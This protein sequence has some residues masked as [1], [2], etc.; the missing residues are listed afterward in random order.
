MIFTFVSYTMKRKLFLLWLLLGAV[1][2]STLPGYR[3]KSSSTAPADWVRQRRAHP[4]KV[5]D[6][7]IGL[8]QHGFEALEEKLL[9]GSQSS[10]SLQPI[11]TRELT[12][13]VV[14]DPLHPQY[15]KHL[16][17]RQVQ[18]LLRPAPESIRAVRDWLSGVERLRAANVTMSPAG[19]WFDLAIPVACLEDLLQTEYWLFQ[20]VPSGAIAIRS[21][22]WSLP[23]SLIDVIDIVTPAN[24]FLWPKA[25]F[26]YGAPPAAWETEGRLPTYEELVEE[27][28]LD[29]GTL[30]VPGED[31]LSSSPTPAEACNRLVI[32]PLCLRVLYGTWGYIPR[33]LS[34]ARN[35]VGI[36]N[37][38]GQVA[39]RSDAALYL[40]R[41][42]PDAAAAHAE[43]DFTVELVNG[44]DDQQ[45]PNTPQQMAARKGYEGALDAQTVLGISWPTPLVMYNVGGRP[46]FH[47]LSMNA[48]N[49]NE[50][51]L[52]WLR[53][54]Q[55][56]EHPPAVISISYADD[57]K[58]VPDEYARRLCA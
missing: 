53:H 14:S 19:D 48:Q 4:E 33:V 28:N 45:T 43:D 1:I 23:A 49:S 54:M 2:A 41:Y 24:V 26:K 25:Q 32:S 40:A 55:R 36:V 42:R 39:N 44:G 22:E 47:P 20:H 15:G 46:P 35:A 7:S 31:S 34:A 16:S 29:R 17:A 10:Q 30:D 21:L 38:L 5:I 51:Y 12:I 27:D 58:L 11:L 8:V 50:P 6:V 37:F 3:L 52:A 13:F 18:K 56:V 9:Q 57:E